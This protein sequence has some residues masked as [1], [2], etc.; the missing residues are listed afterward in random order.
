MTLAGCCLGG[1]RREWAQAMHAEFDAVSE[2]GEPLVFAIGCLLAALREM[3]R[4]E[5]GRFVLANHVLALTLLVPMAALQFMNAA[6][7]MFS[8]GTT[9]HGAPTPGSLQAMFMSYSYLAA[10]P[11]FLGL[12][13]LLCVSHL[14]L[15]WALLERDWRRVVRVSCLIAAATITFLVFISVLF[16][17]D[18]RVFMQAGML[19]IELLAINALARWHGR[20]FSGQTPVQVIR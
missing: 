20:L 7:F 11:V 19:T 9:L 6:G 18:T 10:V 1:S 14:R 3:P 13:L 15:A 16:V 12:W 2:A 5:E 4:H 8:R 17:D